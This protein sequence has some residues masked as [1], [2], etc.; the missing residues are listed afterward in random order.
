MRSLQAAERSAWCS[1]RHRMTLL[2][3]GCTSAQNCF[4]SFA[5]A[6]S[7]VAA[8]A[9]TIQKA[10]PK[11]A[12]MTAT[13][14]AFCENVIAI[15]FDQPGRFP[16]H[17]A[18]VNTTRCGRHRATFRLHL[19][20]TNESAPVLVDGSRATPAENRLMPGSAP[21]MINEPGFSARLAQGCRDFLPHALS[22]GAPHERPPQAR[23]GPGQ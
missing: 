7:C 8:S 3:P 17:R 15:S 23:H 10:K 1:L 6:R 5:Q 14:T 19:I 12:A 22:A 20:E 16:G 2:R 21:R 4:T 13:R 11:T 9:G 18:A